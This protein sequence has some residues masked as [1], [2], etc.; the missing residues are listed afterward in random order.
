GMWGV[1]APTLRQKIGDI[2]SSINNYIQSK[3][4]DFKKFHDQWWLE[5]FVYPQIEDDVIEH[6][7]W[8]AIKSSNRSTPFPLPRDYHGDYV[9]HILDPAASYNIDHVTALWP[10]YRKNGQNNFPQGEV[11]VEYKIEP[12]CIYG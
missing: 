11:P 6:D 10:E 8:K 1:Y 7:A 3:G 2:S 4:P 9:G 5:K 12:E